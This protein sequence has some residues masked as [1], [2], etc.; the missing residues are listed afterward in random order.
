M[1]ASNKSS[2]PLQIVLEVADHEALTTLLET[3]ESANVEV[4][5]KNI[6]TASLSPTETVT[7]DLDVLTEKQ[8]RTLALALD[9]GYYDR[10]RKTDLAALADALDISRSAVSQRIRT[11][12]KKLVRHAF[13]RYE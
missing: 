10:P 3:I 5:T 6:S 7:L 13:G 11:A 4:S 12:E 9:E 2:D 1:Y 8:R